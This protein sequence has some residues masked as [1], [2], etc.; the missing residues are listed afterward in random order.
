MNK[1]LIPLEEFNNFVWLQAKDNLDGPRLNGLAC[2][3][4][5]QELMDTE[6]YV[7]KDRWPEQKKVQC[8]VCEYKGYRFV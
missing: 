5:K 6:P 2:P 1:K 4:C 8:S 3:D 7:T